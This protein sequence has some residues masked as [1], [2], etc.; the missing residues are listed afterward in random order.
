[1]AREWSVEKH[2]L[3]NSERMGLP[4]SGAPAWSAFSIGDLGKKERG[5]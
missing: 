2:K 1:M 5:E 4:G 3:Q